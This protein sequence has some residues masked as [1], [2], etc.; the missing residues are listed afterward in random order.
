[1]EVRRPALGARPPFRD[2]FWKRLALALALVL[3]LASLEGGCGT[4]GVDVDGCR[5]SRRP[6]AA[7]A[8]LVIEITARYFTSGTDVE[9]CI[10]YYDDACL[11]GLA[12]SNPGAS[13]VSACVTAIQNDSTRKDGCSTVKPP[14]TEQTACGWLVPPVPT[15]PPDASEA[16]T[17]DAA[18]DVVSRSN[19]FPSR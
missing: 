13:A 14:Q 16:P 15:T 17:A 10:R 7:R 8:R 12:S 9:A 1:M 3:P 5:Q 11:H 2:G 18:A 19:P 6:A 4:G